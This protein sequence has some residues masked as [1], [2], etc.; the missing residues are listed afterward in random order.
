MP[1]GSTSRADI[2]R[3]FAE[4]AASLEDRFPED[5]SRYQ[6]AVGRLRAP[7]GGV[8]VDAGCGSGRA[9]ALLR[10]AVGPHGQVIGLDLTWQMLSEA[11]RRGR[12]DLALLVQGD[13]LTLP[14]RP[15]SIDGVFAAGLMPHLNDPAGGL[16]E[17]A[18]VTRH[19]GGL[20]I[21]H[22][23]CRAE[24]VRRHSGA[25]GVEGYLSAAEMPRQLHDAGWQLMDLEDSDEGYV[26]TASRESA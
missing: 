20:V 3:F 4:R 10:E 1:P 24:L 16:R 23:V 22:P 6:R 12:G 18:R 25:A 19:A 7:S 15:A 8:V 21:F 17:L 2:Q 14:L 5:A 11:R 13:L 9:L 26:I